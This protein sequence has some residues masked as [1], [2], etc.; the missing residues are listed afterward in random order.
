MEKGI[1]H[2]QLVHRPRTRESKRENCAHYS[3]LHHWTECLIIINDRP[4]G[5][6]PE[7]PAS[8]VPLQSTINS[9]RASPNPL[10]SHHIVT[11]WTWHKVPRLVGKKSP[12]LLFHRT[13]PMRIS[14]SLTDRRGYQ[15][16]LWLSLYGGERRGSKNPS[17]LSSHH[18]MSMMRILMH[19]QRVVHH[20]FH[21]RGRLAGSA[22][23]SGRQPR[24]RGTGDPRKAPRAG[25][26][27]RQR[28]SGGGARQRR[29]R[30]ARQ[31]SRGGCSHGGS[32][33]G[34][35]GGGRRAVPHH[36]WGQHGRGNAPHS[37][38]PAPVKRR[39]GATTE[40]SAQASG[41]GRAGEVSPS[42]GAE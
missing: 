36:G 17:R 26:T 42:G 38:Q 31:R 27:T 6:T 15:R 21:M 28:R 4:L 33:R 22:Q 32:N 40:N 5:E 8:L 39:V 16:D 10:A 13:T 20:R 34:G 18:G 11:R 30:G 7:N 25:R 14:Q 37:T 35:G 41:T 3:R 24:S 23:N 2:I 9:T 1:L 12:V 19:D 29:G